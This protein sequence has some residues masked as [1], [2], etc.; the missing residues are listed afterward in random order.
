[1]PA[2]ASRGSYEDEPFLTLTALVGY[3][4]PRAELR[5]AR[6][7]LDSLSARITRDRPWVIRS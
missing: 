4:V 7:L 6:E 3:Y 1:M 2:L 5:R